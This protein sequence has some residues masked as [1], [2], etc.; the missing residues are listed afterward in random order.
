M[1][2]EKCI[3]CTLAKGKRLCKL[4]ANALICPVCCAKTRIPECEGCT[5]YEK[6]LHF[7][8]DKIKPIS[9]RTFITD[10]NPEIE[11]QIDQALELAEKGRLSSAEKMISDLLIKHPGYAMVQ[12]AMGIICLMREKHD[13]AIR[14][15][16]RAIEINPLFVEAWY[17]KGASHQKKLEIGEMIRAYQKV[18]ELG[19]PKEDFVRHTKNLLRGFEKSIKEETGVNIGLYLKSKEKFD[20]AFAAMQNLEWENAL[21]G[22]Q[23]V[24]AITPRH[25]QSYGNIGLCYAG[26][27]KKR[28]ALEAFDKALQLDP[29]YEP[30]MVNREMVRTLPEGEKLSNIKFQSI[31]YYKDYSIKR[32]SLI[33][34]MID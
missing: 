15:F 2:S 29:K 16:N 21:K 10:F 5:Y 23:E 4:N 25:P 12:F 20:Q 17:N 1:Q 26:L 6:A 32:K 3:I 30:A 31:E 18:I 9:S 33:R 7:G 8:K 28:E 34:S 27:G 11:D 19:D 14:Y 13:E 24:L 22:F